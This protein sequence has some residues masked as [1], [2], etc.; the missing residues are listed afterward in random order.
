MLNNGK[1]RE[2]NSREKEKANSSSTGFTMN[3]IFPP[4]T[5]A[6]RV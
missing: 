2:D 4:E 5:F 3:T 6:P 1:E